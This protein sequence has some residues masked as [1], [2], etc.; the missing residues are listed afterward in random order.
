M[1]CHSL[2]QGIFPIEGS[3]LGLLHC[4][5]I[6]YHLSHQE[7]LLKGI[8]NS[9]GKGH[10]TGH[11]IVFSVTQRH[12][13]RE[14]RKS[15]KPQELG[16]QKCSLSL[17]YGEEN[18]DTPEPAVIYSAKLQ[19]FESQLLSDWYLK[20]GCGKSIYIMQISKHNKSGSSHPMQKSC[21]TRTQLRT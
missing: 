9:R 12:G 20:T 11:L 10:C 2:L 1:D 17:G 13:Y 21:F 7:S 16:L 5:Q 8:P 4:R 19:N 15:E 3:N 14:W 18:I 6:L